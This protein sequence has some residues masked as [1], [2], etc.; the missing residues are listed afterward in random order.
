MEDLN[1]LEFSEDVQDIITAVPNWMIRWGISLILVILLG[2]IFFSSIIRYPDVVKVRLKVSSLNI[3][4][5]IVAKKSGKLAVLSVTDGH[6]VKKDQILGFFETNANPESVLLVREVLK[7]IEH[8]FLHNFPLPKLPSTLNLG[9][10]QSAYQVFHLDYLKYESTITGGYYSKRIQFIQKDLANI[11]LLRKQISS[12]KAIQKLE[13]NNNK[14][15]YLAYRKLFEKN[16]IS[17]N[18]FF[19]E[20][21]KYLASKHPMQQTEISET[22]NQSAYNEKEQSLLEINHTIAEERSQFLQSLK[23]LESEIDAWMSTNALI[24]PETGKLTFAGI[25]QR[26]QNV[27]QNQEV[28]IVNAGNTSFFGEVQIPQYNMGMIR[29]GQKTLIKLHSFPYEEFGMLN[30]HI[31]SISDAAYKDSIF[32]ANI[33]FEKIETKQQRIILKS[34]MMAD[35]EII[36]NNT[37]LLMKLLKNANKIFFSH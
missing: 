31:S 3:P 11:K 20:E 33:D 1:K 28:F 7:K 4:K 30:G 37:S 25:I 15:N 12:Q 13:L 32:F 36:T 5:A 6:F 35:A 29:K 8:S 16:V 23:K 24:S 19:E 27:A 21:N 18:E 22:N 17:R 10:I 2:V 34:G 26:N 9:E 14:S